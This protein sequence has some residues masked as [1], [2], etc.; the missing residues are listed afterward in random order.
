MCLVFMAPWTKGKL[1]EP[2][3]LE[4]IVLESASLSVA[5]IFIYHSRIIISPTPCL[6][7]SVSCE[8]T[9]WCQF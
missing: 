1:A 4:T 5:T 8:S 2:I 7:E 6:G 9:L 3:V